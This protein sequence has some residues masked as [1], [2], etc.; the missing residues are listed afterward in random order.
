MP[1]ALLYALNAWILISIY[2]NLV[3]PSVKNAC[4]ESEN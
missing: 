4:K 2:F 1:L 3:T